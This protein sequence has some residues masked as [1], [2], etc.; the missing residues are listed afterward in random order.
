[1]ANLNCVILIGR[2]TRDAECRTFASGG[3]VAQFGFC[4]NGR[5][6]NNRGEWEDDPMYI[7]CKAFN[8]GEYGKTADRIEERGRK[9]VA[10][11]IEGR[12][13]LEQWE[14]KSSGAKRSKHVI[15]VESIQFMDK[16]EEGEREP[17]MVGTDPGDYNET[18]QGEIPF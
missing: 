14:D 11:C 13:D 18:T 4:V 2:L 8:R 7:D 6:K 16:R 5:K 17:A 3:K 1:M 10:V 12:L 15:V 9:G